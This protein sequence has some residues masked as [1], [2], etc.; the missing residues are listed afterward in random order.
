[1]FDVIVVGGSVAGLSAAT[2][3]GRM[4]HSV[5]VVDSGKHN[6]HKQFVILKLRLK[7]SPT[8]YPISATW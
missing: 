7:T 4:R 3:L 5:M 2:Y 6:I 8:M 1:M